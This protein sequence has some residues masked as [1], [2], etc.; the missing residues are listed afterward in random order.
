MVFDSLAGASRNRVVA[1][2]RDYLTCEYRAKVKG[3]SD[4]DFTR[5]NIQGHQVKV[6]QQTNFTDC[7]LYL[8]QYVESFFTVCSS[9]FFYICSSWARPTYNTNANFRL[10]D[11]IKNYRLPIKQLINWFD[12]LVV[13]KKREDIVNLIKKK[14]AENNRNIILPE[15]QLP[16]ED[17]K[18]LEL[19]DF[20]EEHGEFEE[21]E[22]L[23][24]EIPEVN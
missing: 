14:M 13:T 21:E 4:H 16:T 1:T 20:T 24:N 9:I 22:E 5:F 3:G 23:E 6:P 15:I 17:G 11:P 10:Q 8:L 12:A 7:G 19:P 2:L 18:L